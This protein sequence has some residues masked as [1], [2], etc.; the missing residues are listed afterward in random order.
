MSLVLTT[1]SVPDEEKLDYWRAAVSRGLVPMAVTPRGEDPI[2]GRIT[3]GH[4]GYLRVCAVEADAQRTSRT[5][6]HIARSP[7]A[8]LA[9]GVQLRGTATLV[10][11]G[12]RTA[13]AERDIVVYDTARPYSLD[14]PE[15]F[16]TRVVHLP[17]RVLGLPDEQIRRITGTVVDTAQGIGSVLLPFLA[18]LVTS[19]HTCSPAVAGRL[20]ATVLDFF[21]TLVA[22]HTGS[23]EEG[24]DGARRELVLRVRDHIDRNLGDHDLSPQ[25]VAAAHHI[26]VRYLHRLFQDEGITV[27]RL[28]QRRRLEESARELARGGASAPTVSAVARRWGFVSPAHFSRVFRGCYGCSPLEWRRLRTARDGGTSPQKAPPQPCRPAQSSRP[29]GRPSL[30]AK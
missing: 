23:G 13:V 3:T 30:V 8:F 17:R 1:D 6:A 25:T 4:L 22:E 5:A 26:S 10:Q 24:P 16:S 15:R 21:A 9:V 2:A 12:R 28:V 29:S 27:S 14:Y 7:E 11:D 18:T 20:A 19:A